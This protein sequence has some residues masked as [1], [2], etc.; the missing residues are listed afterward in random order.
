MVI[1]K[2]IVNALYSTSH[3]TVTQRPPHLEKPDTCIGN[4]R[5]AV[6]TQSRFQCLTCYIFRTVA[7]M[8]SEEKKERPISMVNEASNY[9][10]TSDYAVHPMS[11][12]GRVSGFTYC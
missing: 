7:T 1:V 10:M 8:T 12:V 9:S 4:S 3:S 11:P 5:K 6:Y 2:V